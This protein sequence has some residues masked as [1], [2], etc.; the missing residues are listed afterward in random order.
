MNHHLPY[1]FEGIDLILTCGLSSSESEFKSYSQVRVS[2]TDQHLCYR[3]ALGAL[4]YILCYTQGLQ[5]KLQ[6]S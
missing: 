4:V 2:P 3:H 5:R 1:L 6:N